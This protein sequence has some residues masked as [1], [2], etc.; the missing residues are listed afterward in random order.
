MSV[1]TCDR[2]RLG[3]LLAVA[4]EAPDEVAARAADFQ[5]GMRHDR[6]AAVGEGRIGDGVLEHAHLG[7]ADRQRR[8]IDQRR[9]DAHLARRIDDLGAA[10]ARAV[11][12]AHGDRQ[13]DRDDVDR[14]GDGLVSVVEPE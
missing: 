5:R 7:R 9:L 11:A 8:R 3:R 6:A 12:A 13:L 2:D 1:A 10:G 4:I 14:A